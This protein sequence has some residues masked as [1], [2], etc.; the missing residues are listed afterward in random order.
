[1]RSNRHVRG[2]ETHVPEVLH[3]SPEADVKPARA[4]RL[5]YRVLSGWL[6]AVLKRKIR[7]VDTQRL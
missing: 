7:K 6:P 4:L 3:L 5:P 1:M 2:D